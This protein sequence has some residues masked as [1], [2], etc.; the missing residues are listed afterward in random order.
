MCFAG[1]SDDAE[2]PEAVSTYKATSVESIIGRLF[3]RCK[4]FFRHNTTMWQAIS[5]HKIP[6]RSAA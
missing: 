3:V 4:N 5:E 1:L 6:Y 2:G